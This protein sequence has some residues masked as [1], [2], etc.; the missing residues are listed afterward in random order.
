MISCHKASCVPCLGRFTGTTRC[1]VYDGGDSKLLSSDRV[2]SL[3]RVS[4]SLMVKFA[5]VNPLALTEVP[6]VN[7]LKTAGIKNYFVL[8]VI[9]KTGI[10]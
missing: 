5:N 3:D 6:V 1:V 8:A 7:T 2:N 9:L 10:I 4:K